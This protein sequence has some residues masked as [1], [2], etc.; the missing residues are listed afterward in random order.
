M[1]ALR[2]LLVPTMIL[3]P[4][5][6]C[7]DEATTA[8]ALNGRFHGLSAAIGNGTVS[9]YVTVQDGQPTEVGVAL[10]EAALSGLP[11]QMVMLHLP[12]PAEAAGMPYTFMMFGWNP[13]GHLPA[14]TY[15]L[16]HFDFHFYYI[17]ESDVMKIPGGPDPIV[18]DASLIPEGFIAPGN[19]SV[20]AMG[21]HWMAAY[22]PELNGQRFE[23]TMIYGFTRGQPAFIEP[24]ITKAFLE[25]KPGFATAI[26]QPQRFATPE[27]YATRHTIK[28]DARAKEYRIAIDSFVQR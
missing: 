28:Y 11:D 21:V 10:S 25:T 5:T 6:A 1:N 18:P 15:A 13:Q 19:P 27:R 2:Y 3:A 23:K 8:V 9:T 26:A 17:A 4:L 24:M 22:A 14:P 12:F 20:P 16:P 7:D